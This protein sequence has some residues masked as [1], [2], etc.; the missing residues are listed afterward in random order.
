MVSIITN[1]E[2]VQEGIKSWKK[3]KTEKDVV[4]NTSNKLANK[5]NYYQLDREKVDL[6]SQIEQ[7]LQTAK[8]HLKEAFIKR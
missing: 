3:M 8:R 2:D 4:K 6:N 5:K 1:E 7:A